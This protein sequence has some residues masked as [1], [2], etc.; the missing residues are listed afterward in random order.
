M[1]NREFTSEEIKIIENAIK[2]IFVSLR[3]NI[4]I[5]VCDVK[6]SVDGIKFNDFNLNIIIEGENPILVYSNKDTLVLDIWNIAEQIC[7]KLEIKDSDPISK[8]LREGDNANYKEIE[9]Y[10]KNRE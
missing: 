3:K 4:T 6:T 5:V 2:H 9:R 10:L 1:K 7:K 8:L